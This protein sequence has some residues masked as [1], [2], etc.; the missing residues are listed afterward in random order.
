MQRI[1]LRCLIHSTHDLY[2]PHQQYNKWSQ[3]HRDKG[4][5]SPP[6]QQLQQHSPL[7]IT[8]NSQLTPMVIRRRT[9]NSNLQLF[10]LAQPLIK[11]SY[12]PPLLFISRM[13]DLDR[14]DSAALKHRITRHSTLI[15]STRPRR[16]HLC[17]EFTR[18]CVDCRCSGG[19]L[20]CISVCTLC[21]GETSVVWVE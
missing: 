8:N 17:Q 9:G 5:C 13:R 11:A 18:Q 16:S 19:A 10:P 4:P 14:S 12:S 21:V 15:M 6:P 20:P 1:Q 7:S 2:K 3:C